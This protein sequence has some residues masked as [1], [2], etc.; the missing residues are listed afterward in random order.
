[1]KRTYKVC[2]YWTVLETKSQEAAE[3]V[4]TKKKI[5]RPSW[6]YRVAHTVAYFLGSQNKQVVVDFYQSKIF[7]QYRKSFIDQVKRL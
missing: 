4:K 2:N 7:F 1:M 6:V 3:A 5:K